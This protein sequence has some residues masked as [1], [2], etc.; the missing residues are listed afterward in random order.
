MNMFKK[1][2]LASSACLTVGLSTAH[3]DL[4]TNG[5]FETGNFSGWSVTSNG[6]TGGCGSNLWLVNTTGTQGCQSN[7]TTVAAPIS[8]IY[9]AFNTFD[10]TNAN[11]YLSQTIALPGAI[12]NAT[13]SFMDEYHMN[14]TGTPRTF[15]VD[16]YNA[17]NTVLLSNLYLES[18]GYQAN[19]AWTTHTLNVS[20]ALAAQAGNTVTLRFSEIIP[21]AYTGPAG[22]GL[23]NIKLD[24][25]VPEPASM[26]LLG[27]GLLGLGMARRR[28]TKKA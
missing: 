1:L 17:A 23:D 3:A 16:L 4:I 27:A 7:G 10:G 21:Q 28:A 26:A 24:A 18:A 13:L 20:A 11:Y 12:T 22:F 9:G 15:R 25:T 8:G 5:G 19:V 14:Y 2:I 6:G